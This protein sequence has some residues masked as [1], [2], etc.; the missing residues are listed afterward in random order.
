VDDLLQLV[1]EKQQRIRLVININVPKEELLARALKRA[2]DSDRKDD[3]DPATHLKRLHIF[4]TVT[5]PAIEYMKTLLPVV[6]IDGMGGI[7]EITQRISEQ[8]AERWA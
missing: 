7:A 2:A 3:Q 5:L 8:I 1:K 4:E 6:D